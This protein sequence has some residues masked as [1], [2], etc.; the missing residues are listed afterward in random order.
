MQLTNDEI[1]SV[2]SETG[3]V[4]GLRQLLSPNCDAR[5]E[6]A[7]VEVI[8]LHGISLPAGQF[9]GDA[10]IRLFL[11]QLDVNAHSSFSPLNGLKVSA[12]FFIRRDGEILQFVPLT[13]RAW[14][15]GISSC[16]GRTD[17]NDF[18]IG[19]E[20]EGTDINPYEEAQYRSLARLNQSLIREFPAVTADHLVGHSDIAPDRKSDPGP[21][22]D[23][24]RCRC[25]AVI[26][27]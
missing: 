25:D 11:N 22:F 17:V 10:V 9:G 24:A 20:L 8:V 1:L 18:S 16:L 23:W 19:V 26:F 5:P 12:H 27:S 7:Q 13:M 3:W 2:D 21:C 14:H 15:A 4:S 6:G